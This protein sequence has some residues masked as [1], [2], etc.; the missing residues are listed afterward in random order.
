MTNLI[1]SH[2]RSIR[3]KW[4]SPITAPWKLIL[5]M[6]CLLAL[7]H[8]GV[9]ILYGTVTTPT[10]EGSVRAK[11]LALKMAMRA[12]L[13]MMF[14]LCL[15]LMQFALGSGE[16]S[17]FI[18][19]HGKVKA[20]PA[21]LLRALI[22]L[23]IG[24]AT[25]VW[26]QTNFMASKVMIPEIQPFYLDTPLRNIDKA[27]FFGH[28]PY[29]AFQWL[30]DVPNILKRIDQVYTYWA[31]LIAGTWVYC[32]V[33]ERM[34]PSRRY[35]YLLAMILLWLFAGTIGAIL[36]SSAGPVYYG[37]FTGDYA[38]Y[39]PLIDQLYDFHGQYYL[40][41]VN[42]QQILLEMYYTPQMRFGGISAA[43]SL[44]IASSLMLLI[45][46][47][48]TAIARDLLIL[49]NIV[50]YIGS[51]IL[52]W[53]YAVDGLISIPIVLACWYVSAFIVKK[54]IKPAYL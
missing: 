6:V 44:H 28:D 26:L 17:V 7:W 9:Q 11:S 13:F 4:L 25:F 49:F 38:A 46:F 36:L 16:G 32:F 52:G 53:H 30:F 24:A 34:E 37:E 42:T 5:F 29:R 50:I 22:M 2:D 48:K 41:A 54:F 31:A 45:L 19:L 18:K 51:I 27:L 15:R 8:I 47:W 40:D 14:F 20:D 23:A 12:G 3:G 10:V 1:Y 43:P 39:A 35:Q 33:S 21:R